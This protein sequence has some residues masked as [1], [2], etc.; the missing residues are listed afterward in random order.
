MSSNTLDIDYKKLNIDDCFKNHYIVPDYQREYVW[1]ESQI[2]QM[3]S[4]IET[5]Y[6]E[7][8]DKVYFMGMTVVYGGGNTLE[9]I[10]GQQRITTFFIILCA[11][12]NIYEKNKITSNVF[13]TRIYSPVLEDDGT[14]KDEFCLT[15]QYSDST[16]CLSD[17]FH[18][19]TPNDIDMEKHTEADQRLYEAYVSVLNYLTNNFNEFDDLKRFA[20]YFFKK[21]QFV[22]I[23]AKDISDALKIFETINER[24]VG[25]NPMDLLKNM[26][27]MQVSRDDFHALNNSWKSIIKQ[28]EDIKEKPLRFLRYY[29]TATYDI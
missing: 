23:E 14:E 3:L 4:D 8:P 12:I 19:I 7:N 9:L 29:I 18:G 15:L 5:A 28:L 27:F 1:Q 25:L 21:V 17:I 22:Q 26:I 20:V 10:D 13:K 6:T 16:K 2:E 24:G 11:I